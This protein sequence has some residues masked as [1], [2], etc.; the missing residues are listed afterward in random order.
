MDYSVR[1]T[2][3]TVHFVEDAMDNGPVV[4]QA[5]VP[6][7]AGDSVEDIMPRIHRLEHRIYPQAIQWL[8]KGR[9]QIE[10]RKV[11]LLPKVGATLAP[12]ACGELE[13]CPWLVCPALEDF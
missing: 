2:G 9:L 5:A 13:S 1:L 3:C 11:R 12:G 4:I 10:G 6:L 7:N 8:A